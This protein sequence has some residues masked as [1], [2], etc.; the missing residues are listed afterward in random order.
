MEIILTWVESY[1][2]VAIFFSLVFGI[3]GLP[4]PDETLL[5]LSGY[6]ISKGRLHPL[7]ALL[8]AVAGS[9]SGISASYWIGRTLGVR[10][11]HRYGKHIHFDEKRLEQV[12]H[13][14]NR[15][16]HWTLF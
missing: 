7:G 9:W 4:I 3:V 13:W 16:G 12:N 1:G 2:Y 8:A 15:I 10:V 6:L 5:V 11:I 14:F